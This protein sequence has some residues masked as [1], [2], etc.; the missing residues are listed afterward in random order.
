ML[1]R[2]ASRSLAALGA[3]VDLEGVKV[4]DL[5]GGVR[6]VERS[7]E[8]VSR[9]AARRPLLA[10][11]KPRSLA[12]CCG[13]LLVGCGPTIA[14]PEE[15]GSGSSGAGTSTGESTG[16]SESEGSS[17]STTSD[18]PDGGVDESSSSDEGSSDG[19]AIDCVVPT[20]HATI[21]DAIDDVACPTVHVDAG[22]YVENLRIARDVT[23]EAMGEVTIDGGRRG[24]VVEIVGA[25]V[26]IHG[27]TITG[28]RAM[29]GGGITTD[30]AL[31]LRSTTVVAN[32]ATRN[33]GGIAATG[34]SLVIEDCTIADNV[35][36]A[37]DELMSAQGG[38]IWVATFDTSPRPLTLARSSV[39]GN[40]VEADGILYGAGITVLFTGETDGEVWIVGSTISGNTTAGAGFGSGGGLF[41]VRIDDVGSPRV[42]IASSTFADNWANWGSAL[43]LRSGTEMDAPFGWLA[44]TVI[45]PTVDEVQPCG[46]HLVTVESAG[47]NL[48]ASSSCELIGATDLDR[49]GVDAALLPL[50]TNGGPTPTHALAPD[51]AAIDAGDP[52]GCSDPAGELI[53]VDQRG[54]PRV[55]GS[56]CDIGAVEM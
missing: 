15:I 32:E 18:P 51:S 5:H 29:Q 8:G 25:D 26:A 45:A 13:F 41:A 30:G 52:S 33:G 31:E 23:V 9:F 34:P 55:I 2:I 50:D 21:Q 20:S 49:I 14:V 44:G 19:R 27:V 10:G 42:A 7:T 6:G 17:S 36:H 54:A 43:H 11:V 38:G 24:S 4:P 53:A 16:S 47:Y 3:Q 28:G 40:R 22:T 37:T 39:V 48:D 46:L 12:V 35:V 1:V 56:A